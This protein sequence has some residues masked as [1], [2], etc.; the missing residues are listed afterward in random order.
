MNTC[1]WAQNLQAQF[2]RRIWIWM[3]VYIH[4]LKIQPQSVMCEI[5]L[6]NMDIQTLWALGVK[7][8]ADTKVLQRTLASIH[9]QSI[10]F[11]R[12]GLGQ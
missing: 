1:S 6:A 3:D 12:L 10:I 2:H 4:A 8:C 7:I 9:I 11:G 5:W